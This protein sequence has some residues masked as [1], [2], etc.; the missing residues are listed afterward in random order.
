MILEILAHAWDVLDQRNVHVPQVFGVPHP[1]QH[2]QLRAVDGTG[3]QDDLVG[4]EDLLGGPG[5]VGVLHADGFLPVEQD[6]GD[7]ELLTGLEVLALKGRPVGRQE[8]QSDE[9]LWL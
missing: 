9:K 7:E 2:E 6:L 4:G 5:L 8:N 1:R 3:T